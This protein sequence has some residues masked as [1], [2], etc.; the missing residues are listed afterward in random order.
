[1]AG[2]LVLKVV[3]KLDF[4]R[5]FS[6][7]QLVE[8]DALKKC[9]KIKNHLSRKTDVFADFDCE[10]YLR[11]YGVCVKPEYR[12]RGV[13]QNGAILSLIFLKGRVLQV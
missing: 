9:V 10:T 6:R 8:G 12:K 4:G 1:M 2:A 3:R 5:V 13:V 11:Y 7:V